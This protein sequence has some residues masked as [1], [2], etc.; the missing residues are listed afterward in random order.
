MKRCRGLMGAVALV[1]AYLLVSGSSLQAASPEELIK[2]TTDRVLNILNDASLKGPD[3]K[4]IR[5]KKIWNEISSVFDFE[6]MSK[7]ALGRHWRKRTP[8]ERKEFVDLFSFILQDSYIGKIDNYSDEKIVY[9]GEKKEED[10]AL[11]KTKIITKTGTEIPVNYRLHSK[12][13]QWWVYDV[14][15]EGVSL[16]NNYR[17]QFNSILVRSSYDEL[18]KKMRQKKLRIISGPKK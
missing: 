1:L 18:L 15:I 16:V 5:R 6:E 14:V 3:K 4:E 2:D 13:G 12:D 17:N 10:Y 7:R 9:L 8:E 11:V